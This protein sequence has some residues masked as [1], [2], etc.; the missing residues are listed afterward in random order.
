MTH[1]NPE[2][3]DTS[4]VLLGARS[5]QQIGGNVE[6]VSAR[7]RRSHFRFIRRQRRGMR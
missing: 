3:A 6:C 4:T 7:P 2:A 5:I 1:A